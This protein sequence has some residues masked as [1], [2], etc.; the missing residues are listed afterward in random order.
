MITI[1]LLQ[2]FDC[3]GHLKTTKKKVGLKISTPIMSKGFKDKSRL[4]RRAEKLIM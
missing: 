1:V 3:H 2:P 4:S